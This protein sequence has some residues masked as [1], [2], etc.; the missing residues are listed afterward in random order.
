M[1]TSWNCG[2]QGIST[3]VNWEPCSS[4]SGFTGGR[5][6]PS[7]A[8]LIFHL[9][10]TVVGFEIF[11][12]EPRKIITRPSEA[13][14]WGAA[15]GYLTST[16]PLSTTQSRHQLGENAC[17]PVTQGTRMW[18]QTP[19]IF[20]SLLLFLRSGA[21]F[22]EYLISFPKVDRL[23]WRRGLGQTGP[24]GRWESEVH[25]KIKVKEDFLT[26]VQC[27]IPATHAESF[28]ALR[29]FMSLWN[30][31]IVL[32]ILYHSSGSC[33]DHVSFSVLFLFLLSAVKITVFHGSS[34]FSLFSLFQME[35]Q[36]F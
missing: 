8:G 29:P 4:L 2:T 5:I 24:W 34:S 9:L 17:T 26:Q 32:L 11:F 23:S 28:G 12:R 16:K 31:M 36:I 18:S 25:S 33:E 35:K 7:L 1:V 20:S 19:E 14:K 15:Q 13:Y 6:K 27:S 3:A 21:W 30:C 10:N 22:M